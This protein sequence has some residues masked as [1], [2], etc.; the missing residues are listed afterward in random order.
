MN[1]VKEKNHVETAALGRLA[2][3]SEA[4]SSTALSDYLSKKRPHPPPV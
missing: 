4:R 2:S 3:R 1:H